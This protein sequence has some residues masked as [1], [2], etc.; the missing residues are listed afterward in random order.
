MKFITLLSLLRL[1]LCKFI[2]LKVKIIKLC[3]IYIKTRQTIEY[4]SIICIVYRLVISNF[5]NDIFN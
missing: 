4:F 5:I 2:N 1:S 3:K